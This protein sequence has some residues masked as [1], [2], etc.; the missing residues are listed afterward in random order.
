MSGT[1]E[2]LAQS[3]IS[4]FFLGNAALHAQL[5]TVLRI[6]EKLKKNRR[7]EL[8]ASQLAI[9]LNLPSTH[10][11]A[12]LRRLEKDGLVCRQPQVPDLWKAARAVD[13][14]TLGDVYDCLAR[15]L[16]EGKTA[17]QE[18]V[19]DGMAADLLLMQATMTIN[20]SVAQQLRLFDLG[21]IGVAEGGFMLSMRPREWQS[22]TLFT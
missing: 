7:G 19:G 15:G 5:L 14:M 16:F 12:H 21:R 10:V 18:Q 20:Q 1:S 17:Q 3:A 2:A 4:A 8:T 6:L 11:R 22:D 9:S 13:S